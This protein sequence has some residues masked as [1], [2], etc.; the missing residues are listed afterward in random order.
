[1]AG[2]LKLLD[3]RLVPF[4]ASK[5]FYVK[6]KGDYQRCHHF[7]N[8]SK[9]SKSLE[10]YAMYGGLGLD[11]DKLF[12]GRMEREAE[13]YMWSKPFIKILEYAFSLRPEHHYSQNNDN[14][15]NS[16]RSAV[17]RDSSNSH[18]VQEMQ[19]TLLSAP[20]PMDPQ[21]F[22]PSDMVLKEH[23]EPRAIAGTSLGHC[24]SL[25]QQ[26]SDRY[27][28]GSIFSMKGQEWAEGQQRGWA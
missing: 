16:L 3:T 25:D 4:T 26:S 12:V 24:Q 11:K 27:L 1:M 2:I 8:N 13:G 21:S 15:T 7:G 17:N 18:F 22:N 5:V 10:E 28:N 23:F 14:R 20:F 19:F 9:L 6:M